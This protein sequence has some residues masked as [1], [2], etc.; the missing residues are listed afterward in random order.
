[1]KKLITIFILLLFSTLVSAQTVTFS[2]DTTQNKTQEIQG[3]IYT[4]SLVLQIQTT[5]RV[6]CRYS[7]NAGTSFDFMTGFFDDN[8]ETIHKTI[9]ALPSSLAVV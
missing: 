7:Q 9:P 2:F 5:Q 3:I 4:E 1:M 6:R 8:L